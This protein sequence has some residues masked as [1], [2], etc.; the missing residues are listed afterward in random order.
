MNRAVR[1]LLQALALVAAFATPAAAQTALPALRASVTVTGDVVRIGDLVENP[2]AVADAP[3]FRAP[4]LG[5]TGAVATARVMDAI[6]P[7]HLIDIDTR[8]LSQVVVTRASRA[9]LPQEISERI[10]KALAGQFGLGDA[11]HIAVNFDRAVRTVQVEASATGDLQ[12]GALGYD[13]HSGRFDITLT[14]PSSLELRGHPLRFYGSAIA[15]VD[16]VE[17]NRPIEHDEV[18]QAADLTMVQRPRGAG[19][20]ITELAAA[21]G[22]AARHPLRP[23]QPLTTADLAKPEIVRRDD[24]VTLLYEAPGLVLTLRGQAQN[25]GALGDTIGVLNAQTKRVVQGV[26]TAPG[27]VSITP[28]GMHLVEN[29][30]VADIAA[31]QQE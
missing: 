13:P 9:I 26:I 23:G 4:D 17:V 12:V 11:R 16:T 29:A 8:G 14:L 7:Y 6:R 1:K 31:P 28:A 21:I 20:A 15:T 10:A 5:T 2:G 19:G 22:L 3:I 24:T 30:P 27:V 25:S 18:L